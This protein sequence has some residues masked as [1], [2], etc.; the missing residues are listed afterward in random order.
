M[1]QKLKK[2]KKLW[3]E[4]N[5]RRR[6]AN[7]IQYVFESLK[8]D[9]DNEIFKTLIKEIICDSKNKKDIK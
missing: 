3:R 2:R 5:R 6:E 8:K 7:E 9:Q 4:V 1:K